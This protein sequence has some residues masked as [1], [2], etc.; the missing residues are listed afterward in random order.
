MSGVSCDTSPRPFWLHGP[1]PRWCDGIHEDSDFVIDR[2]H[3]SRWRKRI[4]L[5]TMEA[6]RVESGI[7]DD[8]VWYEPCLVDVRI[9]QGYREIE[10]RIHVEEI[11]HRGRFTFTL[12][13]AERFSKAL[14][15]AVARARSD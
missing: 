12:T 15:Q 5:S 6:S 13:E 1:C 11:H 7:V 2:R 10:P 3:R 14:A 8:R 9:D 4:R